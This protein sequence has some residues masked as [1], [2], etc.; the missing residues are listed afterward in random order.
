M[1]LTAG[2]LYKPSVG[3]ARMCKGLPSA[4]APEIL[5]EWVLR[6]IGS[7]ERQDKIRQFIFNGASCPALP[8]AVPRA[9]QFLAANYHPHWIPDYDMKKN[10]PWKT[11]KAAAGFDRI[12]QELKQAAGDM[13]VFSPHE[14]LNRSR[15][16]MRSA[17]RTG[18]AAAAAATQPHTPRRRPPRR[19]CRP[20]IWPE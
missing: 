3:S 12:M 13:Q 20:R 10:S 1:D 14:L 7:A 4:R 8:E 2:S 17:L 15:N 9:R 18:A 6:T 16:L 11:F 5:L 19:H